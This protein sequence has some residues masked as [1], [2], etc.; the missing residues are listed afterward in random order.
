MELR[1]GKEEKGEGKMEGWGRGGE[2]KGDERKARRRR[3][4]EDGKRVKGNVG[5]D[6]VREER[7]R[8]IR[9]RRKERN[10]RKD[11]GNGREERV[12]E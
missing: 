12:R 7:K 5:E 3:E 10:E 6:K 11:V 4:V 1:D 2:E 8:E 9:K